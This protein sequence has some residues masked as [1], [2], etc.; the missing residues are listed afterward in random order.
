MVNI[1][2]DY[3][4]TLTI[5]ALEKNPA[6]TYR[7]KHVVDCRRPVH[8]HATL[9]IAQLNFRTQPVLVCDKFLKI[10]YVGSR[11]QQFRVWCLHCHV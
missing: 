1:D 8:R 4:T 2:T 11:Q 10:R 7:K 5:V 9:V 3:T 6:Y